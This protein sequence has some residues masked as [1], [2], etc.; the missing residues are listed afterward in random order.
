[1]D[2]TFFTG[3]AGEE[4]IEAL[5]RD[6]RDTSKLFQ[7]WGWL[8]GDPQNKGPFNSFLCLHCL[9]IFCLNKFYE[10]HCFPP[11]SF[12][13]LETSREDRNYRNSRN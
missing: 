6:S 13:T 12:K 9:N 11:M 1:M 3:L 10:N 5:V 4:S 2:T 7:G 8:A